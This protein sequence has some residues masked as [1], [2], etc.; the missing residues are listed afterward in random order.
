MKNILLII[1]IGCYSLA[2]SQMRVT[3]SSQNTFPLKT[4]KLG[5]FYVTNIQK[6]ENGKK[7]E[8][9]IING[10][11][12]NCDLISK[13][14]KGDCSELESYLITNKILET[15]QTKKNKKKD[16]NKNIEGNL[17]VQANVSKKNIYVGE[18]ILVTYKFFTRLRLKLLFNIGI[19]M[20]SIQL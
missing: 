2:S 18:Q 12:I 13:C 7:S 5:T 15:S 16:I 8:K 1:F 19:V 14:K 3:S 11:P 20:L 10:N 6:N 4:E 9:C 17:F